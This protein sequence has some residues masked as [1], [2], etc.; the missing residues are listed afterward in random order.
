M[1][2]NNYADTDHPGVHVPEHLRPWHVR[3]S[4]YRPVNITPPALRPDALTRAAA[5]I[6]DPEAAPQLIHDLEWGARIDEALVPFSRDGKGWPLNPAGRTGRCGRNLGRW[7]E[8]EA[9]DP[10]VVAGTGAGRRVLLIRRSDLGVWAIPGGKVDPGET[11]PQALTRELAEETGV[12]LTG[13]TPDA[14][15]SRS[16]VDDWR[17]TDHAWM[18]STAALYV[19]PGVIPAQGADDALEAAWWPLETLEG[20]EAELAGHGGLYGA[21]RPLLSSALEQVGR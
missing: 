14:V 3:F 1:N 15:L 10:V 4:G 18:C 5:W 8:N 9:A 17:N 21:H 19:L 11:A 7:G 2:P 12:D 16:Y 13:R 6:G 20:L